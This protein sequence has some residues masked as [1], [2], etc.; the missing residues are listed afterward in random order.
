MI[1]NARSH[2]FHNNE[3]ADVIRFTMK[4]EENQT[5]VYCANNGDMISE[6]LLPDRIFEYGETSKQGRD[7]HSGLGCYIIKELMKKFGGSVSAE[8]VPCATD[9]FR[10]IFILTF[11]NT[12]YGGENND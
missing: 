5:I 9:G 3:S 11:K 10:T 7:A 12:N 6:K 8:S 2:G 4:K 1:D